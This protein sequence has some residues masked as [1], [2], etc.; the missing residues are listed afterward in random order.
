MRGMRYTAWKALRAVSKWADLESFPGAPDRKA[1]CGDSPAC[2]WVEGWCR[3]YGKHCVLTLSRTW[4]PGVLLPERGSAAA[5]SMEAVRGLS[6]VQGCIKLE[7]QPLT[8]AWVR[9][10]DILTESFDPIVELTTG[11][12]LMLA[13]VYAQE[14]GDWDYSGM[15]TAVLKHKVGPLPQ[16]A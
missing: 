7:E 9:A 11:A 4:T 3:P 12:D 14:L 1:G 6:A 10:Q 8:R 15:Y 13:M 5:A 16:P 2:T